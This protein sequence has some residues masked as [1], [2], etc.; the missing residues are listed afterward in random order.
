MAITLYLNA[1]TARS[2]LGDALAATGWSGGPLHALDMQS[3]DLAGL[4]VPS[5]RYPANAIPQ[6]TQYG[7]STIYAVADI[8][9][10]GADALIAAITAA[11]LAAAA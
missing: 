2:T 5:T 8:E 11:R 10:A 6:D 3:L 4:L 1:T 9:A 7:L